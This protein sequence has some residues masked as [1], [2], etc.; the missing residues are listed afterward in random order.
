[1]PIEVTVVGFGTDPTV[2]S[3]VCISRRRVVV[4]FSEDMLNN[5]ALTTAG[6]YVLTEQGASDPVSVLTAARYHN[7][8]RAIVLSTSADMTTGVNAYEVEVNGVV[9]AAS[10][11]IGTPNTDLFDVPDFADELATPEVVQRDG[12]HV[13][14]VGG[15]DA[16]EGLYAVYVGPNGDDTDYRCSSTVQGRR[17][18][19]L[20]GADDDEVDVLLPPLPVGDDYMFTF[21]LASGDGSATMTTAAILNV[22]QRDYK[23][24]RYALR[25]WMM[26]LLRRGPLSPEREAYPL[27]TS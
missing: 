23:S 21:V 14:T 5:A 15:V 25:R 4:Y 7:S 6:N 1:M 26:P 13:V 9:D 3:A 10:N 19:V 24:R 2:L 8:D 22:E 27:E 11:P 16:L 12:G 18:H 20:I 17:E